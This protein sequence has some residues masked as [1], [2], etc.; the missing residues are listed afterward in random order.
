MQ[1]MLKPLPA[2]SFLAICGG[3]INSFNLERKVESA[4]EVRQRKSCWEKKSKINFTSVSS[5]FKT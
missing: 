2:R 1:N 4:S 5:E 3:F